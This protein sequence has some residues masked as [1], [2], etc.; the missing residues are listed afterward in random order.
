MSME[1]KTFDLRQILLVNSG[2]KKPNKDIVLIVVD[3][4]SYEYLL[5]KYGEWPPPRDMYA[6]LI[7]H[8]EKQKPSV[9]AFDLMFIKS[10]KSK[11]NADAQLVEAMK[12]NNNVFTSMNF[13]NQ[14]SE[15]RTPIDLDKK[16]T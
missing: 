6:K 7:D 12:K 16:Y 10:L 2:Y 13:D 1:N 8:L 15:V 9:I 11:S 14:T 3:D 5:E 4:A